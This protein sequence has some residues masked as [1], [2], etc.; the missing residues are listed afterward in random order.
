[1]ISHRHKF[2]F[3]HTQRTGGTSIEA[4]FRAK[5]GVWHPEDP[6][7]EHAHLSVRE[8]R[9]LFPTEFASYFKF[10]FVRN[11]WDRIVSLYAKQ[12]ETWVDREQKATQQF[13]QAELAAVLDSKELRR[14]GRKAERMTRLNNERLTHSLAEYCEQT[15]IGP[16]LA[17]HDQ[18]WSCELDFVGRFE[19]LGEDFQ[20]VLS[21]LGV[22]VELPHINGAAH[23]PYRGYYDDE[24]RDLV[25]ERCAQDLQRWG[26]AF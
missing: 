25:A 11:P 18:D 17:E 13:R 16:Q 1:M 5:P 15:R 9:E 7:D 22:A 4:A 14:L 12:R 19:R 23:G 21:H 10:S 2:I 26:Y 20:T 8:Y 3:V 6:R 24:A